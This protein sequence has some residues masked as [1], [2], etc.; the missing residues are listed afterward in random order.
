MRYPVYTPDIAPYTASLQKALADGWI[1]SQGEFIAKAREEAIRLL[2]TP[3][4]VLVNNGTS[5][6]HLLYKSIKIRH[7]SVETLYV[8][9]YV[10]VAVWNCALY[11][12]R[13]EQLV[14]L[15]TDPATLNPIFPETFKPNSALVV[16]H[17]LG[18]VINVPDL[19]RKHP[20]L[21][22]VEDCC[23]AFLETYEG[24]PT[25]TA[26]LCAAVS[27][28][29]N[30]VFTTGEGGLW[31]TH[32]KDLFET[33]HKMCH[34]GMTSERYVYDVLGYNYRM[35]NL[36]A[37]LLY[38]QLRDSERILARK[39][40]IR[41]RYR[42]CLPWCF[43]SGLWMTAL[44]IPGCT[45]SD[46][47]DQLRRYGID[48]RPMFYPLHTH[49]HLRSISATSTPIRH[50]ELLMLP[51]SPGLTQGDQAIIAMTLRTLVEG[52]TPPMVHRVTPETRSL[53]DAFVAQP[54]P[55]TFRYFAKRT[56]DHCLQ[57]HTVTLIATDGEDV[58]GYGHVDDRWI[59]LCVLP[60]AQG[61]GIGRFLLDVLC[62]STDE[63]PLRLTVDC[64][65][66]RA[67]S[68]YRRKGFCSQVV[69]EDH[70]YMEYTHDSAPGVDRGS[71]RQAVDSGH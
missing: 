3:Y 56:V 4:V 10:F 27:F 23:E 20:E 18:T 35:T 29:G 61:K 12:Y 21:V 8:P 59:G 34:H 31:Y 44:R 39:R 6:T 53:L 57:T 62:A 54:H 71:D 68:L 55:S 49:P 26:G 30:K 65:N 52:R 36:Q 42:A 5:A 13:P 7:P 16:V 64:G 2:G 69:T 50:E 63:R 67:Q 22:I 60:R 9:D 19:Q 32:D 24:R 40:A 33:I 11:E 28:F 15:P 43:T 46:L 47:S 41:D 70:V 1:S 38:E 45:A 17:N 14:V 25:G 58:V 51:S 66:V 37:A 48:T